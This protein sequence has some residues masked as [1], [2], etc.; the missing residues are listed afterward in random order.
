MDKINLEFTFKAA[1]LTAEH[2]QYQNQFELATSA[3]KKISACFKEA[4][5][6]GGAP[7]RP[8]LSV[9][10][11]AVANQAVNTMDKIWSAIEGFKPIAKDENNLAGRIALKIFF[12]EMTNFY[13]EHKDLAHR[14]LSINDT[15]GLHDLMGRLERLKDQLGDTVPQVDIFYHSSYLKAD[16]AAREQ[17]KRLTPLLG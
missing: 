16:E 2:E 13:L 4:A 6:K 9:E 5:H 12:G 17:E 7:L 1:A 3:A 14:R 15:M 11:E 8:D 10:E